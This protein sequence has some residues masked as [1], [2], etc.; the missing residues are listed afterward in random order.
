MAD[1]PACYFWATR[2]RNGAIMLILHGVVNAPINNL[3]TAPD[4]LPYKT[5]LK[6]DQDSRVPK[7]LQITNEF[8]KHISSGIIAPGL[9]LPGTRQ[10]SESLGVNRRTVIAA[11]DELAAQ[12]WVVVQANKGC[13]VKEE[14]PYIKP[15]LLAQE[16]MKEKEKSGFNL[17]TKSSPEPAPTAI[18]YDYVLNDGYPDVRLAPL[19]DLAKNYSYIMSTSLS[20]SLMTYRQAFLGD[21][22]LRHELVKYLAETRSIHVDI[23]NIMLTRGSLMAFHVLFKTILT[24]KLNEVVVGYPGWNEGH[25]AIKLAGGQLNYVG[26]DK[27]GMRVEEVET[28]CLQKKIR[29]VF[30][31][32]HHHYPTTVSLSASRRMDLLRLA[33]KYGFAIIEDDYDYDFHYSSA[34]ILPI[35]STD[36]HGDVAYVGSF[37]KTIAPTLRLG[38]IVAPKDLIRASSKVSKFI[39]SFGNI[40]LER[41]VAMLFKD[42]LVRRHLRKALTTYRER[43]DHFCHLL[44]TEL[45]NELQFDIPEGGLAVWTQLDDRIQLQNL[46]AKGRSKHIK[47]PNELGFNNSPFESNALRIGFASMNLKEQEEFVVALKGVV[48]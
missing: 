21:E 43:R 1:A 2:D 8:I 42:G 7:Y 40:A 39:D 5:I 9:K 44:N 4:M 14:L 15:K 38:F 29:A 23:D 41:S 13:Y 10:L 35:A 22:V 36:Y 28:L 11:L 24:D 20:N 46:I 16:P 30:V 37:S 26:V 27:E 19:K 3:L 17:F 12:G 48:Y 31:V 25:E 6:L 47:I 32:S 45:G 18:A 33:Q 34:P